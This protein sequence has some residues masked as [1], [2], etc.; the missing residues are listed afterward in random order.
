MGVLIILIAN[1][2]FALGS[3]FGKVALNMSSMSGVINSFS[4]FLIGT[5][6][7]TSY[8]LITKKSF[9]LKDK[10]PVIL[11]AIFNTLAI[12]LL[13]VSVR[14][15]T[16]T[17]SNLLHM[18]FPVFVIL[19]SPY[20]LKEKINKKN[21][22]YLFFIMLGSYIITNPSFENINKGDL[23]AFISAIIASFSVI[24][25]TLSRKENEGYLIV[26]YVMAIGTVINIPFAYND[27]INFEFNAILPVFLGGFFGLLGQIFL[28]W[29]Y[30][31][32]DSSTGSLVSASRILM[33]SII[34]YLLLNEEITPRILFGMILIF[35][36]LVG[37][38]GFF[39]NKKKTK[40]I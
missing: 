25:L 7:M 3:Y 2:F 40:T 17:N 21:Y 20:I 23:L 30:K 35:I 5:I 14:Y 4:R 16:I 39:E 29:G 36:S 38:S 34:G 13:S 24:C 19:F 12:I 26:F 11:R 33:T 22:I 6:V 9:K 8:I 1:L 37:V 31:Y 28:T 32:V 10:K 18:T 15:T 27:I